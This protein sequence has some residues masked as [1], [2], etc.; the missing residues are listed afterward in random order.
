MPPMP[1]SVGPGVRA[2]PPSRS[3]RVVEAVWHSSTVDLVR[4]SATVCC[5]PRHPSVQ[6]LELF[7]RLLLLAQLLVDPSRQVDHCLKEVSSS[8]M[9]RESCLCVL[10]LY[11]PLVFDSR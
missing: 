7:R 5:R 6:C 1:P 4:P 11:L 10:C 9:Y 8:R 2:R 3:H